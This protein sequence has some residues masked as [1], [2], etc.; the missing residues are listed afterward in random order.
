MKW[1]NKFLSAAVWLLCLSQAAHADT[2]TIETIRVEGLQRIAVGT[3]YTYLPVQEGSVFDESETPHIIKALYHTGFFTDITVARE[4]NDLIIDVIE[5]PAIARVGVSGNKDIKEKELLEGLKVAGLAEGE[6]FDPSLLDKVEQELKMQYFAHGKY[7]VDVDATVTPKSRNRVDVQIEIFE[8]KV[9]KIRDVNVIGNESYSGKE[10][11]KGFESTTPNILSF[12]TRKGQY[13]SQKLTGDLETLRSYYLD[14]GYIRFDIESTQVSITPDKE[15]IYVT[16]NIDE[17]DQYILTDVK[18]L[19][20]LTLSEEELYAL[21]NLP[22][23]ELFSRRLVTRGVNAIE[24]RLGYEGYAF[25]VVNPLTEIDDENKTVSLTYAIEP[26]NR[27]YVRRINFSGNT[28]TNDEVLRQETRQMEGAWL[29][30]SKVNQTRTNLNRTGFF[31]YVAVDT[32][33]VPGSPDLVDVNIEVEEEASGTVTGGLGFSQLD[34]LLFNAGVVQPNFLGSGRRVQFS[35]DYSKAY[36]NYV[37][38]Y[39]NPYFTM[40]GVSRGVTLFFRKID[41]EE[42]NVSDYTTDLYGGAVNY[43]VPVNE[44]NRFGFGYKFE[45]T[46]INLGS[47]AAQEITDFIDDEGSDFNIVTLS[48]NWRYY[49]LDRYLFPR[50]GFSFSIGPEVTIPYASLEYYKISSLIHWYVPLPK[51]YIFH[52]K[53]NI[54]FGDGYLDTDG[55]PFFQNYYAGGVNSVRGFRDNT[56]GPRDEND[57][58]L[59]GNLRMV[60]TVEVIMPKVLF[61]FELDSVRTSVFL[62]VGNV[63]NTQDS[64]DLGKLRYSTGVGLIWVSPLGPLAFSVAKTL[65]DYSEDETQV[66]QFRIG[67]EF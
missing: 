43:S 60:G 42:L 66:F 57:N 67:A 47:D 2:F 26:G 27:V 15:D 1:L 38:S 19:G 3:V 21:V 12:I 45:H 17:G 18:F 13:S 20:D 50:K 46:S 48:A 34:G 56:L 54:A 52:V 25:A 23:G 16:I 44:N 7:G 9:A 58:A 61:L 55:L 49:N 63:Y 41:A 37:L 39:N 6:S 22:V 10:I 4:G 35:F 31:R 36:T 8:G 64:V 5:R 14:R 65:T 24:D 11:T 51:E 59:G 62:D 30:T 28:R 53:S 40:D 33:R 32:V 29:D